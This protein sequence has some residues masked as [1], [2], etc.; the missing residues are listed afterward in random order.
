MREH[1]QEAFR[2]YA[3]AT[4]VDALA[5]RRIHAAVR[6]GPRRSR[7]RW[8]LCAVPAVALAAAALLWG[9]SPPPPEPAV[10][11][12]PHVALHMGGE[13]RLEG[14]E[15]A[16][17]VSWSAGT[18]EVE[19][20]PQQGVDLTIETPEATI[21]VVGTAFVVERERYAT[22]VVVQEGTVR[23]TCT[24]GT[25]RPV[26]AGQEQT[27]LPTEPLQLLLRLTELYQAGAPAEVRL[28]SA[29]AGLERAV[30]GDPLRAEILAHHTRAAAD[31][32]QIERALASAE[33]YLASGGGPRRPELLS[34]VARTRY[35][36]E[37]CAAVSALER[38]VAEVPAGPERLLLAGCLAESDR[39]RARELLQDAERW[40]TPEW[41]AV[42]EALRA[43]LGAP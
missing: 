31:S 10:L 9:K 3:R 36:R 26:T 4:E 28:A 39:P 1:P 23:L 12:I 20:T 2:A 5:A 6:A 40:A 27:C 22:R 35:A 11:P 25:A 16:P 18:L 13:G 42:A 41:R 37:Q 30:P 19:V 38:A 8:A 43:R 29:A 7:W 33:E 14:T 34:F 32:G 17:I 15:Q 21:R 24:D